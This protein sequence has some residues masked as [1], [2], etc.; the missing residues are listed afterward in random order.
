MAEKLYEMSED[1]RQQILRL[2]E[3]GDF[4]VNLLYSWKNNT[5][6]KCCS[7]KYGNLFII[8]LDDFS[9]TAVILAASAM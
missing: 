3:P 5:I 7:R 8:V 1:G 4:S 2:L 6:I 9:H